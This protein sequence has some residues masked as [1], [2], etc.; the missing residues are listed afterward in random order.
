MEERRCLGLCFNCNE[1][2]GHGH[3]CVCQRLFLIDVADEDDATDES[4]V[5]PIISVLAIS[6]VRTRETMQ[7]CI[8]ISGTT[9]LAL[10]DSG[11]SH[12]FI[13]EEAA[14]RT[15]LVLVPQGGMRVTVANGDCVESPG[16]FR[17]TP[18]S[19]DSEH[20]ATDFYALPLA[21]YDVVLGTRWLA[22]LGPIL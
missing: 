5:E 14:A 8:N 4:A 12:N 2:F 20:F 9:F 15:N 6:G 13:T 10:L 21:G 17:D 16:M 7:L 22:T 1:K 3:N 19:I 11:S 18:F